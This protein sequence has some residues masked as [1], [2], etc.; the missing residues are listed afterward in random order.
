[1]G[2]F[3]T[4]GQ[5]A[6]ALGLKR[7]GLLARFKS[8]L[9]RPARRAGLMLLWMPEDVEAARRWLQEH[10]RRAPG[11]PRVHDGSGA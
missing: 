1:M 10:P 5:V 11:R 2:E 6:E 4:S 7:D 3:L 8:G 9:P